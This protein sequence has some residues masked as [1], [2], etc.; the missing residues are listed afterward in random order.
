MSRDKIREEKI[1]ELLEVLGK[2]F[3][4]IDVAIFRLNAP[5]KIVYCKCKPDKMGQLPTTPEGICG[6]CNKPIKELQVNKI[7]EGELQ[8]LVIEN[9]LSSMIN[10][11]KNQEY[12][13]VC[14]GKP[15]KKIE[16]KGQCPHCNEQNTE[17]IN[18]WKYN[19]AKA[20]IQRR[21]EWIGELTTG[22]K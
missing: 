20:L 3:K 19:L 9:C 13:N 8:R 21:S 11:K 17:V 7:D 10:K 14:C 6:K 4:D 22:Q 1:K 2:R 5:Y 18:L 15:M 12:V 16:T